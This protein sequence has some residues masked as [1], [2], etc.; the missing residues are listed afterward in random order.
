MSTQTARFNP[1]PNW[2]TPPP[3]WQPDANFT[4]DPAWGP[5]PEGW[6]L[7]VVVPPTADTTATVQ[8]AAAPHAKKRRPA[9]IAAGGI[10]VFVLLIVIVSAA[11]GSKGGSPKE[12]TPGTVSNATQLAASIETTVNAEMADPKSPKYRPGETVKVQCVPAAS[13]SQYTCNAMGRDGLG[14]TVTATVAA[15]GTWITSNG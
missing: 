14:Y 7:W 13:S 5:V 12:S 10:A 15:D 6:Q 2:P 11:I 4:P 8:A 1:P 3:G 9:L